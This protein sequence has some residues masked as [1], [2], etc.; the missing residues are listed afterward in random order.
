MNSKYIS[1][2]VLLYYHLLPKRLPRFTNTH[3]IAVALILVTLPAGIG[4]ASWEAGT[5]EVTALSIDDAPG[6]IVYIAD[7]HLKEGNVDHVKDLIREI[8][9]LEPSVVLIGGDFVFGE[10]EED[11]VYQEVWSGIDAPVYAILGNHDYKA[12]ITASSGMDKILR[13][14]EADLSV[15]NFDVSCMFDETTDLE[16]AAALEEVLEENGVTVLRNEYVELTIDGRRVLIVGVDDGWAGL[17]DPPV[18]DSEGAFTI[19]L[20][21][22]PECRADWDADLILAGHTH[23]GQ[24]NIAAMETLTGSGVVEMSGLVSNGDVPFYIS[25][26]IGTSNTKSDLR[27]MCAPEIVVINPTVDV[28]GMRDI[29]V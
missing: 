10:N 23:G 8:N 6:N 24:I 14:R 17:S 3:Y 25:R 12:G 9:R 22:E 20:I 4:Y 16:Y 21:H 1:A 28:D 11:F 7:P 2:M 5:C 15:D 19:Y 18:V 29:I 26:G 27:F 13:M